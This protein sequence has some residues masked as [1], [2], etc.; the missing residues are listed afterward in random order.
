MSASRWVQRNRTVLGVF[1]TLFV[2]LVLY[3]R[4]GGD[5]DGDAALSNE[6]VN[7]LLSGED[8][9]NTGI[10]RVKLDQLG[11]HTPYLEADLK[12]KNWNI[13]G[14]TLIKNKNYVRLT[15]EKKDQVGSIFTKNSF[16]DKGFEVVFKFSING[17]AR[18]NGLKGDGFAM[19]L[20]DKQL[21]QGPV[22]GA[23]DY[24]NGLGIFFDTYRNAKRGPMFPYISVMNGNGQ[25]KYDKDHDG[26][27][28]ELGGC[29][30]RGIYNPK[31]GEVDARLIYTSDDGYLSLDY[32]YNGDW[33]NCF[34][35]NDVK[36]PENRFL[37]FSAATGDLVENHD[38]FE[39]DVFSLK[40]DGEQLTSFN[41][42]SN[43]DS[44]DSQDSQD[45]EDDDPDYEIDYKGRKRKRK[46]LRKKRS[47]KSRARLRNRIR[48][49][50]RRRL[51]LKEQ[52]GGN[53]S[54][55]Q[56]FHTLWT[57]IKYTFYSIITLIILYVIFTFVRVKLRE[58]RRNQRK[59][60]ILM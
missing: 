24:F 11:L 56:F 21:L 33:K 10:E 19:F 9:A 51:K 13:E 49:S 14:D 28:N 30:A 41:Q 36:I 55:F 2:I 25:T 37:G 50:E 26:K 12:S 57:L 27:E 5:G 22:F 44:Q 43:Q 6:E 53:D 45:D 54:G 7:D 48:N 59:S 17:K 60:G 38:I 23:S 40:Q 29:S 46:N 8:Q 31:K 1:A 18:I 39:A 20:T 32:N 35:L 4:S 34:T 3:F 15:S 42:V 52:N 16:N 58:R 47:S